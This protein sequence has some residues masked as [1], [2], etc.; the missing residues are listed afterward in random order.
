MGLVAK[1]L[2][3][4]DLSKSVDEFMQP[5]HDGFDVPSWA[6]LERS[7]RDR[8]VTEV[9]VD[10]SAL[11]RETGPQQVCRLRSLYPSVGVVLVC[12]PPIDARALFEIGRTCGELPVVVP[13]VDDLAGRLNMILASASGSRVAGRVVSRLTGLLPAREMGVVRASLEWTHRCWSSEVLAQAFGYSRP[14]LSH[15]LREQGLPPLGRLQVWARMFHAGAWLAD[16]GRSAESVAAQLEYS[17]GSGFR[18]T[19]RTQLGATPSG[20]IAAGG[21]DFVL[22]RFMM[23]CTLPPV[24]TVAHRACWR[25]A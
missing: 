5:W 23:D 20:V 9:L 14:F 13:G 19:L 17:D 3:D 16:P 7:V 2:P 1:F 18:R 21:L 25:V 11:D 24:A 22:S 15:C 6:S 10:V 12:P 4:S 8:P